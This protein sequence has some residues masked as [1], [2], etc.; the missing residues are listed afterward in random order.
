MC[1]CDTLP[2][3]E[4]AI[5][6]LFDTIKLKPKNELISPF[7]NALTVLKSELVTSVVPNRSLICLGD[8]IMNLGIEG[9]TLAKSNFSFAVLNLA[10]VKPSV[11]DSTIF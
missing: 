3:L 4:D 1:K 2:F 6:S 9:S 8:T 11:P 10:I 5:D 7:A